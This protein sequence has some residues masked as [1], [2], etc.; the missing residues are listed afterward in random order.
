MTATFNLISV[1][2]IEAPLEPIW[3]AIYHF[4]GWPSWWKG[5]EQVELLEPG[6]SNRIG[7]VSRE[8][9]K[10]KLPYKLRFDTRVVRI[11]PMSVIE[12]KSSGELDGSGLMRFA[13]D[14]TTTIF[15]VDWMVQT[16]KPWMTIMSPILRPAFAWN[17]NTI[18]NWGAECLARKVGAKT[19]STSTKGVL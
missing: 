16:T 9:W 6:D 12:V 1:W 19:F 15:Q 17:H 5:V 4:E 2:K 8:V 7:L 13:R 18:M 11:E 10:S 3:D 14:G